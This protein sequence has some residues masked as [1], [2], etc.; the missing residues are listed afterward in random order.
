MS[1][2]ALDFDVAGDLSY[3]VAGR[4]L[5]QADARGGPAALDGKGH[6]QMTFL[7]KA[8][9]AGRAEALPESR[10]RSQRERPERLQGE[11]GLKLQHRRWAHK[12]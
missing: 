11:A 10:G 3:D 9:V 1:S 6:V 8:G 5:L 4:R 7:V 2:H 12:T